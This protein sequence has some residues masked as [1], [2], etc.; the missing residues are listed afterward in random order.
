[1]TLKCRHNLKHQATS[2]PGRGLVPRTASAVLEALATS[3]FTESSVTVSY[4]EIYNEELSDL[5]ACSD[6]H[7]KLD[8]KDV[9]GGR[10]VCCQGLSEVEVQSM[11]DI[12]EVVRRAQEKRRVAETRVN[13]RSSRSHSIFTMKVK[14][15]RAVAGGELENQ[16]K[17]HLVDLAGSECAKKGGLIYAEDVSA[18]ARMLAGQEEERERRSINQSLLTLGRVIT[19]LREGSGRVP[20]RDSKL[21]LGSAIDHASG[22]LSVDASSSGAV[23]ALYRRGLARRRLAEHQ[24]EQQNLQLAQDVVDWMIRMVD[25]VEDFEKALQLDPSNSEVRQQLQQLRDQLRQE[26]QQ[27]R[28]AQ[29]QTAGFRNIFAGPALYDTE[30]PKPILREMK[31]KELRDG[32]GYLSMM[33]EKEV[34]VS[35]ESL[36]FDYDDPVLQGVDLELRAGRCMGLVGLN[37]S[38]K[39]TLARLL[40]GQLRPKAGTIRFLGETTE[41]RS[42]M[43]TMVLGGAVTIF[44]ALLAVMMPRF[45]KWRTVG[46]LPMIALGVAVALLVALWMWFSSG[47]SKP[48]VLVLHLSSETSDKDVLKGSRSIESVVGDE[49]PKWMSTEQRRRQVIKMLQAGGFQMYNQE[50]GEPIGNPME[51]IRDGLRFGKLSGGQQHLIYILRLLPLQYFAKCLSHLA[52]PGPGAVLLALDEVLGGLDSIRQPRVLRMLKQLLER[53]VG[54]LYIS[55]ELHQLHVM[56]DDLAFLHDGIICELGPA[57]EVLQ[58]PRHGATKDYVAQWRQLPG[59]HTLGG[60]LAESYAKLEK[61]EGIA[62]GWSETRLLQDALGGRCK[63]VIIATISPALASVEETISALSYAEQAAG[64]RNRPVA[65]SLLRTAT[66]SAQQRSVTSH[67]GHADVSSNSGLGASEWA[68]LEMKVTYLSQELEEAQVA[69][70]RK[71]QEAQEEAERA[72]RAEVR[73]DQTISELRKVQLSCEEQTFAKQRFASLAAGRHEAVM[74]LQNSLATMDRHRVS[75]EKHLQ[76]AKDQHRTS[77]SRASEFCQQLQ[78]QLPEKVQPLEKSLVEEKISQMTSIQSA[79][80]GEL[81]QDQGQQCENLTALSSKLQTHRGV[82]NEAV[83]QVCTEAKAEILENLSQTTATLQSIEA[84]LSSA[85]RVSTNA[86]SSAAQ[87]ADG[88]AAAFAAAAQRLRQRVASQR[89]RLDETGQR[90]RAA[91]RAAEEAVVE[92]TEISEESLKEALEVVDELEQM[93]ME[94][95]KEMKEEANQGAGNVEAAASSGAQA[96]ELERQHSVQSVEHAQKRWDSV[97]EALLEHAKEE[98]VLLQEAQQ[99]SQQ[100]Q[101]ASGQ[102]VASCSEKTQESQGAAVGAVQALRQG[103]VKALQEQCEEMQDFV[104]GNK[105]SILDQEIPARPDSLIPELNLPP[106]PSEEQLRSEFQTSRQPLSSGLIQSVTAALRNSKQVLSPVQ[107]SNIQEAMQLL[108]LPLEDK[109]TWGSSATRGLFLVFEGLDRSGKSTQS[110]KLEEYLSKAGRPVKWMCFPNRKT[111]IGTAIDLYLRRQLELPDEAVHRLFSANRWE[112]AKAIVEDLRAG[113]TIICDRYA[114]SGVAYSAAKGL[115]FSWCQ[116]PD[117]GLPCPDGIFFLHID[118][119]VGAARSNFGDERY[120]NADMQARV[121][122]QFKDP[123]LRANVNWKDVNGARDMEV[124]HAE[125][126]SAVEAIRQEDQENRQRAIP[127]LWVK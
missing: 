97:T 2:C 119:K 117:R 40:R 101:Q 118:E 12:L 103:A 53:N 85:Q 30:K 26:R 99:A 104:E 15:Q 44:V 23:K 29:R 94:V 51:Y 113:T 11:E 66:V 32:M 27:T 7:Q 56:A 61:D 120:E 65:S 88:A 41:A 38:G 31:G 93:Q 49:L 33:F 72:H 114:F 64:I 107:V 78:Q 87:R 16:G 58:A 116:A 45:P 126:R 37:A 109:P 5:L 108:D 50:T 70:G 4:L 25:L 57:A 10:G 127:R 36:H 17:L 73:L 13:A 77:Q 89:Q 96:V 74:S 90:S 19:A 92:L 115:G 24:N 102:R 125:I 86:S 111:P 81:Q 82:R 39:T 55:T 22:A 76:S 68:E 52:M 75:L 47:S 112:M 106:I 35:T 67:G 95:L 34:L 43:K 1:M 69:L 62:N 14:C 121:R 3:E 124:I 110:K 8:L 105:A 21:N 9:G 123:R 18:A 54:M 79:T 98:E 59:G 63:T 28:Q 100:I 48:Q 83:G 80:L 60:K 71:Y 84:A 46:H 6:R 91:L 42:G 122:A 20:Y